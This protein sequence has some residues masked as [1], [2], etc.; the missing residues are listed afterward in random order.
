M[1]VCKC[2]SG[3]L[4]TGSDCTN[5]PS[6]VVLAILMNKYKEDGSLNSIDFS[7]D[8]VNGVIP[9]SVIDAK[10]NDANSKDR[11]YPIGLFENLEDT[12]AEIV[13]QTFNSGNS[14]KIKD[15]IRSFTGLLIKKAPSYVG[16]LESFGC[17]SDLAVM[18]VDA[19]GNLIGESLDGDE[20][21]G[22]KVDN[23]TL[24]AVYGK[25]TDTEVSAI[26]FS[27]NYAQT[28]KDA[29]LSMITADGTATDMKALRG[30]LDVS[31]TGTATDTSASVNVVVNYGSTINDKLKLS[32]LEAAD[33][34]VQNVSQSSSV[35]I[36]S[37][38]V[39][40]AD[41]GNYV[42]AYSSGVTSG[43]VIKISVTKTGYDVQ[44][45]EITTA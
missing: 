20:L 10:I 21:Y 42:L 8:A 22:I 16:V 1:A 30:L 5:N 37:V 33:F 12:R 40:D 17:Q 4:N 38:D 13:T 35:T 28:V 31:M 6:V 41:N 24:S 36:D 34:D 32:S 11:W 15:G 29:N 25:T 3:V 44:P 26:N 43:D 18:F 45:L 9:T 19:D 2:S 14:V 27:F 7:A 39:S 23:N